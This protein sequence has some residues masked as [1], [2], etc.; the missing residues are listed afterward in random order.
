MSLRW[1]WL[2]GLALLA[3]VA[4][5]AGGADRDRPGLRRRGSG[6]PFFAL[7]GQRLQESPHHQ[8]P[9]LAAADA[10]LPLELLTIWW[11]GRGERWLRVRQGSRRGWLPG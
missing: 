1:A 3:P 11:D 10:A 4:L 9:Q 6:E 7:G 8:A 2:L 5:P